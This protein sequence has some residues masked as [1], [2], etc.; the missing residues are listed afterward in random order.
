MATNSTIKR[1]LVAF[2]L[3]LAGCTTIG[4]VPSPADFPQ[5]KVVVH[6]VKVGELFEKCYPSLSTLVKALGGIPEG[7]AWLHWDTGICNIYVRGDFPDQRILEH[8]V[9]H[10]EGRD[11]PGSSTIADGWAAWKAEIEAH[12]PKEKP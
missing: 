2:S 10:C 1:S 5:L 11:H 3:L 4:H 7:C 9:L 12:A 6:R 8:E